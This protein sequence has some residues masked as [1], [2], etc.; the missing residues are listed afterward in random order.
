LVRYPVAFRREKR[1]QYL[2]FESVRQ[3]FD[4]LGTSS[5]YTKRNYLDD[6]IHY[7]EWA[8]KTPDQLKQDR[9]EQLKSDDIDVKMT[10]EKMLNRYANSG[11]KPKSSMWRAIAIIK[12]F[13]AHNFIELAAK[14]VKGPKRVKEKDYRSPTVEDLSKMLEGSNLR[15]R[16]ILLTLFQSGLREGSL[17]LLQR[18]HFKEMF[19]CKV[20]VHIGLRAKELKGEYSGLEAHTFIGRDA[21]EAIKKYLEWR[22]R[23]KGERLTDDSYLFTRLD[24]VGQ[25]VDQQTIIWVVA[26]ACKRAGTDHFSPHDFRRAFQTN[27][28]AAGVPA[29]WVKKLMG[30]KL[31]GEENPYSIP[32]I[33]QLR[34]AYSRAEPKLTVTPTPQ[35][36][37][38]EAMKNRMIAL[39]EESKT[40]P[41]DLVKELQKYV[42]GL[43][44]VEWWKP[45]DQRKGVKIATEE[46]IAAYER[47]MREYDKDM[48]KREI[49]RELSP[50]LRGIVKKGEKGKRT[51]TDGNGQYESKIVLENELTQY[52]SDGWEFVASLN[53]GKYIVRREYV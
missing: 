3:W 39:C 12:S 17:I 51:Q 52:L 50:E 2:S 38:F 46:D 1:N 33:E 32:K 26:Q 20:P 42:P 34:E 44:V 40:A 47:A 35:V 16:A 23:V 22:E 37:R 53:S 43:G 27:L 48:L 11:L 29:N 14:S 4:G 8:K 19:E 36:D 6:L 5:E 15:D 24:A 31:A 13:Y 25:P 18:K 28:E 45:L 7:C 41:E 9:K 30:H 10:A 49:L 21:V